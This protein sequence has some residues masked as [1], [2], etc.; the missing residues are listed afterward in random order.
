MDL[1]P[2]EAAINYLG[3]EIAKGTIDIGPPIQAIRINAKGDFQWAEKK[4]DVC[5]NEP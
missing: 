5:K 4:P 2:M 1:P 3:A